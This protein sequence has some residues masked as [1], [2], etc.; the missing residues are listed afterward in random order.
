MSFAWHRNF[1]PCGGTRVLV[2]TLND[3]VMHEETRQYNTCMLVWIKLVGSENF[4]SPHYSCKHLPSAY[5][6]NV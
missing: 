5:S 3:A 2:I 4:I 1:I 6:L